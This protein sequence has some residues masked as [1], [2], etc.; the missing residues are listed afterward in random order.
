ME[1]FKARLMAKGY[2]QHESIDYQETFTS[3]IMVKFIR[4]LLAIVAGHDYEI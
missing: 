3:V 1:I 2:S 4:I